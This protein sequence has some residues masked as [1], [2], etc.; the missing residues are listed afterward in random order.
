MEGED[1]IREALERARSYKTILPNLYIELGAIQSV[2]NRLADAQLTFQ[3]ALA[4]L[5]A[6]PYKDRKGNLY[7]EVY[8]NLGAVCFELGKYEEAILQ[9]KGVSSLL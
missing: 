5:E 4:A 2:T 3:Q 1:V 8:K 6:D 9:F 7:G